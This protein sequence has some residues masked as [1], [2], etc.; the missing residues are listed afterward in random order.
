MSALLLLVACLVLG[1][2][3]ARIANP[4]ATLPQSLN[5]W[6]I[7]VAMSALVLHLIPTLQ[8]DWQF[9]FLSASMWL[10][11]LGAWAVF[12]SLG[13]AL[14][15][16]R[17]RIGA[18]TLGCGLGNTAF[19]GFPMIEALRGREGVKLALVADQLGN[20]LAFA[21]GG[22]VVAALYSGRSAS[23]K[24]VT[25]KVLTFP[26]FVA[27]LVGIMAALLGGWPQPV[28]AIFDRLGATLVP[29]ALFSV[30]LQFRLQFQRGQG[31]AVLLALGWKLALAPLV[32]WLAGLAI[33]VSDAILAIA[34]LESAMA[35]MISAAILAEQNDL[36]PQLANTVLGIGIA[37]SLV[38]VPL[39]DYLLGH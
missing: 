15:W 1:V 28:D 22:T 27:L 8:F 5:W 29:I 20:F 25:R 11:F 13:R 34:V 2:L 30:G 23:A 33:G 21:I 24:A 12:A 6:V 9:W 19:I 18:L 38:T 16:S 31:A 26:P 3:V 32:V 36:E 10:V 35:P 17:A 37:L 14:H 4:P 39:A 7:N